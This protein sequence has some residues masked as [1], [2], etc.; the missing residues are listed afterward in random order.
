MTPLTIALVLIAALLHAGWNLVLRTSA[1]TPA[2]TAL[3][4]AVGAALLAPFAVTRHSPRVL[5]FAA[6]SAVLEAAYFLLLARA[7]RHH[8]VSAVYPVARGL[9]PVFVAAAGWFLL[10]QPLGVAALAGIVLIAAG[11]FL[12]GSSARIGLAC[13]IAALIAACSLID[14]AAMKGAEPLPY[15]AL[16]LGFTAMLIVPYSVAAF[17][18]RDIDW[19]RVV[20]IGAMVAATGAAVLAAFRTAPVALVSATREV[21]IVFAVAG[22]RFFLGERVDRRRLIGAAGIVIGVIVILLGG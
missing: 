8:D 7:Y 4:V 18:L 16:V 6:V 12:I 21:S 15:L 2:A 13:A 9:A 1:H 3:A 10:D 5:A 19:K 17:G 20:V 14:G 11:L 22:G